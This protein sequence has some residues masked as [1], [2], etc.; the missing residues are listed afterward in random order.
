MAA[1]LFWMITPNQDPRVN[2]N[3][4]RRDLGQ[5]TISSGAGRPGLYLPSTTTQ[6]SI[7]M[8]ASN[9]VSGWFTFIMDNPNSGMVNNREA[10]VLVGAAGPCLRMIGSTVAY[11]ASQWQYWDGTAWVDLGVLDTT[12]DSRRFDV[13]WEM[14]ETTGVFRIY[15]S[16]A[17]WAEFIGNTSIGGNTE[18]TEVR[19]GNPVADY[20]VYSNI[21]IDDQDTRGLEWSLDIPTS[22]GFFTDAIN[23]EPEVDE[24]LGGSD[25]SN[26]ITFDAHNEKET[27]NIAGVGASVN[28]GTVELVVVAGFAASLSDPGFH[29][30][31]LLYK[32]ATSTEYEPPG[33][34]PVR[35][36]SDWV[37]LEVPNNPETGLPW[38]SVAEVQEFQYGF[39]A[40]ELPD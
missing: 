2:L 3:G 14:N 16:G 32:A 39:R 30:H 11:R 33:S 22:N 15:R 25:S 6:V 37:V 40:S 28:N 20:C 5:W 19:I 36:Y 31:P 21:F 38:A 1:P 26:F 4:L 27:Y 17:F 29:L 7:D 18:I 9:L 10:V 23:G 24:S 35:A 13:Q 12:P 8:S 34:W